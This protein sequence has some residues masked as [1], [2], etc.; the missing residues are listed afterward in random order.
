MTANL[1]DTSPLIVNVKHSITGLEDKGNN[2]QK[3][4]CLDVKRNSAN[5]YPTK[6]WRTFRRMC[7]LIVR[8]Q[9]VN[10]IYIPNLLQ[11]F[12]CKKRFDG[13]PSENVPATGRFCPL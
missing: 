9:G 6:T 7:V 11:V 1:R 10:N 13:H 4:R 8:L 2:N 3:I 5:R 12:P